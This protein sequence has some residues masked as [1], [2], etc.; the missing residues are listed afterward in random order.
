[1]SRTWEDNRAL[2]NGYWRLAME[3]YSPEERE[4][5]RDDLSGLDQ[6]VLYEALREV[7][8][9]KETPYPQL[10]WVHSAYRSILSAKR[11]AERT[12]RVTQK[13]FTGDRLEIDR[14]ESRRIRAEIEAEIAVA[15]REDYDAIRRRVTVD[16]IDQLEAVDAVALLHLAGEKLLGNQARG[17]RVTRESAIVP[18]V[19]PEPA[20]YFP[21]EDERAARD[22]AI[23]SL[24]GAAS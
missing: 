19:K 7:K 22:R 14:E 13:A 16:V 23:L 4:L 11:A 8:R 12:S 18:F 3:T 15:G 20:P 17:G 5:W 1:M 2:I 24:R 6:D 9:S 21:T 10:A